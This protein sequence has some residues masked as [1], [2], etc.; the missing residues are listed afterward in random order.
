MSL[1]VPSTGT[2][3]YPVQLDNKQL[4]ALDAPL[5]ALT[6][7]CGGD[8]RRLMFAYFS[9]LQ[10]RTDFYLVPHPDDLQEGTPVTMGFREGD[11]EKLLLAAFRQFPLRRIPK[12][13][14]GTE[15]TPADPTT[16]TPSN[17]T[18]AQKPDANAESSVSKKSDEKAATNK[19]SKSDLPESTKKDALGNMS[20]VEYNEEGEQIPDGNGGSTER[21]KWTQTIDECTVL[22]GIPEGLKGKDMAVSI[23]TNSISVKS[24]KPLPGEETSHTFVEGEL[25]EKIRA[26]ESTWSL[27]GGVLVLTLDKLKKT[28]WATV[29]DGDEKIDT[30]LIDSRR[31]ISEYDGSTQAQIR[32]IMFDQNQTRKGLQTSDEMAGKTTVIPELPTGVE[33]I[34]SKMVDANIKK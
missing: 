2:G 15:K 25:V 31:H 9:F 27:E 32:K 10:R 8:L 19:P 3:S 18:P 13:G 24:K 26:D 33:Y 7:Q 12:T 20:G 34:D 5:I 23:S 11:A 14:T 6:N 21:Y 29:I 22:I 28:F 1:P 16:T 17:S 30:D 4:Q